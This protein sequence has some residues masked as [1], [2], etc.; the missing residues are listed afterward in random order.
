MI[1]AVRGS[2]ESP[3]DWANPAAYVRNKYR[4][5][6][7]V[8]WDVYTR[9]IAAAPRLRFSL[10]PVMYPAEQVWDLV[11]GSFQVYE[12]SVASG[13]ETM[14]ADMQ[15]TDSRCGGTVRYIL[16]GYSQGAWVIHDA[17]RKM[18]KAQLRRVAGVDLFGDSD[19][20]PFQQIVRD[21]KLRDSGFGASAPADPRNLGLP[22]AV[23]AHAGSWCYPADPV[24][25]ATPANIAT[26]LPLCVANLPSCPH[27]HYVTGG[28]TKKAAA[29]LA[30]FLP[31]TTLF[32]H[33]TLT[34]PPGGTV[35]KPYRWTAT[36]SCGTACT[37]ST[38]TAKLPPGLTFTRTGSLAGTPAR[39]GTYTVP[40]TAT[41]RYGRN[42]AGS[43]TVAIAGAWS[44]VSAGVSYTCGTRT[45]GTLWCWGAN[46]YGEL[47]TGD[48]TNRDTLTRVG[49]AA[50]WAAVSGYFQ[51]T[52]ATRTTGTLWCWGLNDT[53]Q[54]GTGNID[55]RF[56]PT[57]AGTA[58]TWAAVSVADH[59]GCG[60]R[61]D[62]TLW[63]WGYN[64]S[65]QLGTGD[66]ADRHVPTRVGTAA[67]WTS[68]SAGNDF[69]CGTRT[70]GTLWCWGS[71][72]HGQLGTG[73]T[74]SRP[75]PTQVGTAATWVA[76]ATGFAHTCATRT[77]GTLWCW[78]LNASGQLGTGDTNDRFTPTQVGTASTWASV[79]D[80]WNHTC[81]IRTNRTNRTKPCGAGG[82]MATVSSV[83]ATRP[84]A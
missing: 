36:A 31:R 10:D 60:T 53:G 11:D 43:V 45:D 25:Q 28:E 13:V 77:I 82:K 14:L 35:G 52:C 3:T 41:A 22:S 40:V 80:G 34:T 37:W 68:V 81:G 50:T 44:T 32:P 1:M 61:T 7:Q 73:D 64:G 57:Q 74:T 63:C 47:G 24:C 76:V 54:L 8:N 15:L 51:H 71:N 66:T 26:K 5:A 17:L 75:A 67:T 20:K 83:L 19:F 59:F 46:T 29:F 30:P 70:D 65:G 27:F 62:G 72:G 38:R 39:A 6:G 58:T 79:A 23:T 49:T 33:L 84:N 4:G 21:H 69:A 48:T 2:G 56:L 12:A 78:G 55:D 9:I 16:T 42:A 18:T